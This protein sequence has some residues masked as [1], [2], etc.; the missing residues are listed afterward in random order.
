MCVH[1]L[2]CAYTHFLKS[3]HAN[4][5]LVKATKQQIIRKATNYSRRESTWRYKSKVQLKNIHTRIS[6][7]VL[8]SLIEHTKITLSPFIFRLQ[9]AKATQFTTISFSFS[10][11][12]RSGEIRTKRRE[13]KQI[14]S[15][16]VHLPIRLFCVFIFSKCQIDKTVV[17]F[18]LFFFLLMYMYCILVSY[19]KMLNKIMQITF[20]FFCNFLPSVAK[21]NKEFYSATFPIFCNESSSNQLIHQVIQRQ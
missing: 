3:M 8:K 18:P 10:L 9:L 13:A 16:F 17:P 15:F 12:V 19:C 4:K 6:K 7:N 20:I 1:M 2:S 14:S 11:R 5:Q 21:R